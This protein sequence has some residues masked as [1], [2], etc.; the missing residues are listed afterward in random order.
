MELPHFWP[1]FTV[2]PS[3]R[4]RAAVLDFKTPL[5]VV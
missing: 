5:P 2:I 4:E 3:L 1:R